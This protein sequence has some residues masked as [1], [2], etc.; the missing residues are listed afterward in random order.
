[1]V[2]ISRKTYERN[3]V[4]T[5]V[6]SDGILTLNEKHTK[7]LDHKNLRMITVKYFSD[8]RKRRYKW[9]DEPKK[10]QQNFYTQRISN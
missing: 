7:K 4:K 3:G 2:N 5:I 10:I 9:V 6:D 8:Q 1:M